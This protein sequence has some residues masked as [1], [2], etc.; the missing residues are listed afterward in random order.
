[1]VKDVTSISAT[2]LAAAKTSSAAFQKSFRANPVA[3]LEAKGLA[4]SPAEAR[5][6]TEKVQA[7][8]ARPGGGG[9]KAAEVEVSVK[10]K[11]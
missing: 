2:S 9:T 1:M 5:R 4:I 6:L 10:V 3:A 8:G 11:F 7:L